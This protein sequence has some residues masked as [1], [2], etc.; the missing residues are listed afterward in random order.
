LKAGICF[1][2]L[3][4]S[5]IKE[6]SSRFTSIML[7][8]VCSV[9]GGHKPFLWLLL[10]ALVFLAAALGLGYYQL[11]TRENSAWAVFWVGV[12]FLVLYFPSA[13]RPL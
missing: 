2:Q 13:K 4:V 7:E 3:I 6:T 12:L 10:L 1:L 5:A 11:N 8:Q 9:E